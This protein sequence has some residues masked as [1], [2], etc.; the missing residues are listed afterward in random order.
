VKNEGGRLKMKKLRLYL[1][2]GV[3]LSSL[4]ISLLMSFNVKA[5]ESRTNEVLKPEEITKIGKCEL[6]NVLD[7]NSLNYDPSQKYGGENTR[8]GPPGKRSNDEVIQDTTT[9]NYEQKQGDDHRYFGTCLFS[10]KNITAI[11]ANQ[12]VSTTI[13]L[14]DYYDFLYAPTL[15]APDYCRPESVAYYHYNGL[16]TERYWKVWLHTSTGESESFVVAI[17]MDTDF[18]NRYI[19]QDYVT[20]KITKT[21]VSPTWTVYLLDY[22]NWEWDTIYTAKGNAHTEPD[23]GGAGWNIWEGWNLSNNWPS[24]PTIR[25]YSLQG[26]INGNW[27]PITSTYGCQILS[28]PDAP[29]S[30]GWNNNYYDWYVGP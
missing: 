28:M 26:Y 4:V 30:Y 29:Y 8:F 10:G 5:Q 22:I 7:T 6:D 1:P 19:Y 13:N 14:N 24:L 11:M 16:S 21:G 17:A 3:M 2:L 20:T 9:K 27:Y 12:K 15:L 25:S 23:H 18:V